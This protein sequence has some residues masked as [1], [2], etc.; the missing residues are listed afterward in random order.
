MITG[1]DA[2]EISTGFLLEHAIKLLALFGVNNPRGM[3]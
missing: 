1:P 2:S 3:I